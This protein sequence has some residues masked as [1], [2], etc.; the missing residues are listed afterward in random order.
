MEP[1][2]QCEQCV[3]IAESRHVDVL[4]MDA[5]SRTGVDDI[6]EIIDGVRYAP[7]N[8]R[9]KVYIIDEVHMLS[10]NAFNALLKTLEEPPEH[11]KFIF[12]T[13][14]IRKVPVTVL[15]RCQRFDLKRVAP[16]VLQTLFEKIAKAEG[17]EIE[18]GALSL[19]ARAAEGSARDGL[20]LL[21]QAIAHG[22]GKVTE[23]QMR[24]MLGVIDRALVLDLF[25]CVM[26]GDVPGALALLRR[27]YDGGADPLV[28]LEDLLDVVHALTR[29]KAAGTDVDDAAQPP[30]MKA[31]GGALSESLSMG[32]LTRAWQMLLKGLEEVRMAPSPVAAAEMAV[33][34]LAYAGTLPTPGELLRRIEEEGD[35]T[36]V[37]PPPP[38]VATPAPRAPVAEAPSAP[39]ADPRSF[40]DVIELAGKKRE[41]LLKTNLTDF[42]HLVRFRPGHIDIR[43]E[44]Q[45]PADLAIKLA[46]HLKDWTGRPWVVS[47]AREEGEPTERQK[48]LDRV[49]ADPLVAEIM[50]TF[51]GAEIVTVTPPEEPVGETP[52]SHT[53]GEDRR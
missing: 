2:G 28:I 41:L 13:T 47:I 24:D 34:R 23:A 18:E 36:A 22:A 16:D 43:P 49:N 51:P 4:E 46:R 9:F 33:I 48:D 17:A 1:C 40:R 32:V 25:E 38:P 30:E 26:K 15:S 12:A 53:A 8:A 37:S 20:S 29:R 5:A 14:E 10:K 19:I 39:P 50:A 6:R 21:D 44:P 52:F 27:Q 31:R 7:V 42:V 11:V 35:A 45:A 3:A